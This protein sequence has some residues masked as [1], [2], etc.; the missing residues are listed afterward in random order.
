M[1]PVE[2]EILSFKILK[3]LYSGPTIM[4]QLRFFNH[5][6]IDLKILYQTARLLFGSSGELEILINK[7]YYIFWAFSYITTCFKRFNFTK[8][9]QIVYCLGR[10]VGMK[11]KYL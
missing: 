2:A 5:L 6:G 7:F 4:N 11:S 1:G 9:L 3:T 8:L 10:N